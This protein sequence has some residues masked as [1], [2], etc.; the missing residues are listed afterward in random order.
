M[1]FSFIIYYVVLKNHPKVYIYIPAAI[2][3]RQHQQAVPSLDL[4]PPCQSQSSIVYD[5]Q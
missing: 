3:V 4:H 2:I 5:R 1:S